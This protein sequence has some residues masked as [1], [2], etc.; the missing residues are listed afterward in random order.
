MGLTFAVDHAGAVQPP[1]SSQAG[2]LGAAICASRHRGL[3]FADGRTVQ[4]ALDPIE[5]Q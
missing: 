2:R 4:Y 5:R 1:D 3:F